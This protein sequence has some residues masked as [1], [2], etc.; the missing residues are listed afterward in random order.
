MQISIVTPS[1]NQARFLAQCLDSVAA[2]PVPGV[3]HVVFDGGSSDGSVEILRS[4]GSGIRWIS[5][6]D[7]GQADAVNQGIRGTRGEIVGWLNSDD[8]YYPG[9]FAQVLQAFRDDESID[10]V[11]GHADHVDI[12]G[13]AYERFPTEPWNPARLVETCYVCQPALFFRRRVIERVGLLDAKLEYCMDYD[14]WLRFAQARLD[15]RCITAKLAASRMYAT[16]KSMGSRIPMAAEINRML[17]SHFSITPDNW[18]FVYG[19]AVA[20]GWIPRE[21]S[22]RGYG[23]VMALATLAAALRFNGR[24]SRPM[25]RRIGTLVKKGL[26]FAR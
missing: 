26:G 5:R 10:A 6:K 7:G 4:R 3:E 13:H 15:V 17:R 23:A 11:Y 1:F 19:H 22:W 8:F 24:V 12:D 20:D 16:N 25:L 2:Q 18:L 21:T 14:Y 9:S